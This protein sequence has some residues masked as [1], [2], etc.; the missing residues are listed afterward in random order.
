MRNRRTP[1]PPAFLSLFGGVGSFRSRARPSEVVGERP[2]LDFGEAHH[3]P[4]IPSIATTSSVSTPSCATCYDF[5]RP[6]HEE[7]VRIEDDR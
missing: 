7:T 5:P 3:P 2:G 4:V 1:P 6:A